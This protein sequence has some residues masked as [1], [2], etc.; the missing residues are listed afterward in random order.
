MTCLGNAAML[1]VL[2]LMRS[3]MDEQDIRLRVITVGPS[4]SS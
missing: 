2:R 3:V 4:R 1:D